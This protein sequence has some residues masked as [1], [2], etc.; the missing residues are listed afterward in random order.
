[1]FGFKPLDNHK[2]VTVIIDDGKEFKTY[3]SISKA[4][5]GSGI[6]YPSLQQVKKKSKLAPKSSNPVTIKSGGNIYVI[7]FD[8]V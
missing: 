1:M 6:P 5:I 2:R 4:L 3:E 8:D 7:K